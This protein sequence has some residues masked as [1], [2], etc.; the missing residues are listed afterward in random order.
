MFLEVLRAYLVVAG[1]FEL[2][3]IWALLS[4]P[5]HAAPDGLM[6]EILGGKDK[7]DINKLPLK[8]KNGVSH[9]FVFFPSVLSISR[10]GLGLDNFSNVNLIGVVFGIHLVEAWL[11]FMVIPLNQFELRN[12]WAMIVSVLQA[13]ALGVAWSSALLNP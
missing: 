5:S 6:G 1:I 10:F 9:L 7:D 13:V 2:P 12:H 8:L 11:F 4:R 3:A